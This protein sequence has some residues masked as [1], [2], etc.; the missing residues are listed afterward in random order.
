MVATAK[1]ETESGLMFSCAACK[2]KD[3]TITELKEMN[4]TL[5]ALVDARAYALRNAQPPDP[6]RKVVPAP[7][8]SFRQRDQPYIPP[9]EGRDIEEEFDF[10][11]GI[12]ASGNLDLTRLHGVK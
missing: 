2:A 12:E 1:A 10:K 3:Q 5:L 4:K 9:D 8:P 6:N 7:V 11:Q